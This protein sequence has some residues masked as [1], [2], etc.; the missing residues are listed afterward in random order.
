M[1]NFVSV[2]IEGTKSLSSSSSSS[3]LILLGDYSPTLSHQFYNITGGLS[4][5][6]QKFFSSQSAG[7]LISEHMDNLSQSLS[8]FLQRILFM[9]VGVGFNI[10]YSIYSWNDGSS[11]VGLVVASGKS[12]GKTLS[13]ELSQA[14]ENLF[15]LKNSSHTN[16]ESPPPTNV[17]DG[18]PGF[19]RCHNLSL[20]EQNRQSVLKSYS[21]RSLS[22]D[23]VGI[24]PQNKGKRLGKGFP[25]F[26]RVFVISGSYVMGVPYILKVKRKN[27]ILAEQKEII[28]NDE[29]IL[30][31][32]EEI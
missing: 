4:A 18:V 19:I 3:D 5:C 8:H 25:L 7:H 26:R 13:N 24:L 27:E 16:Y 17:G 22:S 10:G 32:D 31:L 6:F 12:L 9:L 15:N 14:F 2:K 30:D 20:N 21:L 29:Y 11:V 1:N 28:G 23:V